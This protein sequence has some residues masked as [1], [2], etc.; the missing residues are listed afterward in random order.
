MLS[1]IFG[2]EVS[3]ISWFSVVGMLILAIS[4]ALKSRK[5]ILIAHTI[6]HILFSIMDMLS[7]MWGAFVQD[8]FGVVKNGTILAK[9]NT[10]T[11][12]IIFLILSL[13][14]GVIVNLIQDI[15]F[16]NWYHYLGVIGSVQ[17]CFII[18]Y[19][20][21]SVLLVK[22]SQFLTCVLYGINFL[23]VPGLMLSATLNFISAFIALIT[24]TVLAIKLKKDKE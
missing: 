13:A 22:I 10:K 21:D 19:F 16:G 11:L 24:F 8:F 4:S 6:S 20:G 9:K 18:I 14:L 2:E 17:F 12:N 15:T 1:K 5:K 23:Y 7:S 3:W